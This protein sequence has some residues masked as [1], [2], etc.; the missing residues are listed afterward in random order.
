MKHTIEN[1]VQQLRAPAVVTKD[2]S[3]G[4]AGDASAPG[5]SKKER[6]KVGA[7]D[8]VQTSADLHFGCSA[9]SWQT[10]RTHLS[11]GNAFGLDAEHMALRPYVN[12]PLSLTMGPPCH[13]LRVHWMQLGGLQPLS[14][15]K[16][17]KGL[18]LHRLLVPH[19]RW[20]PWRAQQFSSTIVADA[21]PGLCSLTNR[22]ISACRPQGQT[23]ASGRRRRTPT[24]RRTPT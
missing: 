6:T 12:G 4:E 7:V 19:K 3:D 18:N 21:H 17:T 24:A 9:T 23:S 1:G 5:A 16:G 10:R 13:T 11:S 8:R 20:P 22:G 15:V 14:G 2:T